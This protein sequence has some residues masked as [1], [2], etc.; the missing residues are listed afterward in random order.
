M[1]GV[2]ETIKEEKIVAIIR[3]SS[4][5]NIEEVVKSLY[6]GGIR[7]VEVTMNTPGSLEAIQ[8]LKATNEN[9]Y[10]GAGTVLNSESAF[11]A[12]HAG[13]DFLLAPTLNK[14]TIKSANQY[15]VP[16][17]PGVATPTEALQAYEWGAKMVKFFPIRAFGKEYI[18]DIKG[19]LPFI[20]TMAVGGVSFHNILELLKSGFDS[21]G[22]G[23]SLVDD[24]L[25]RLNDF[26]A[27][28]KRAEKFV[29]AVESI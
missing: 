19:P 15:G 25:I 1:D 14:N 28:K 4:S 26:D 8:R 6:Q 29:I 21:V 13:A 23:S 2:F 24:E 18:K 17:I 27:I 3:A 22:V 11:A 16:I 10:I 20:N 7:C 9:M 5:E 12:I